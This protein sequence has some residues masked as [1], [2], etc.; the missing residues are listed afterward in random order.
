MISG[1]AGGG[2]GDWGEE[3]RGG[4]NVRHC[5][6]RGTE[7]STVDQKVFIQIVISVFKI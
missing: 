4:G 3:G 1:W 7:F 5:L 2:D 6:D